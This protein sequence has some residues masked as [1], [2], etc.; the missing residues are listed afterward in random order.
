MRNDEHRLDDVLA[1][2]AAIESQFIGPR[3]DGAPI[4]AGVVVDDD[5]EAIIHCM[6]ARP[7]FLKGW[8]KP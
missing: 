7:E 3:R 2:A 4:E 1:A 8:W 5:G 6:P